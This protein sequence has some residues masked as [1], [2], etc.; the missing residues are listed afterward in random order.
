MALLIPLL[1]G[2]ADY[3]GKRKF[4][5]K[6]FTV[7]GSISCMVLFF[8]NDAGDVAL[9]LSAFI[10]GTIGFGVG[11]VFYNAYLPEIATEDRFD[12]VSARGYAF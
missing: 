9:G 4:F 12:A 8:F 6:L 1:S 7:I 5:L 3:S 11:I 10:L 2:I